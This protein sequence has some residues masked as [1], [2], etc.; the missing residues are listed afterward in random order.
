MK[1]AKT[2]H[3]VT[4][5]ETDLEF[6]DDQDYHIAAVPQIAAVTFRGS[7]F[8][9]MTLMGTAK[10]DSYGASTITDWEG[11]DE[12]WRSV[13]KSIIDTCTA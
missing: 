12:P 13:A 1:L 11:L 10:N 2:T 7:E 8:V 5:I 4:E 3:L 6:V 9:E